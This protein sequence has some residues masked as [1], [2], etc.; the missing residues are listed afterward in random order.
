MKALQ[1]LI[2][3]GAL[4]AVSWGGG[5]N[6]TSML[7]GLQER[8]IRP[9]LILFADT[10]G[11]KPETYEHIFELD[12]W[13]QVHGM[14]SCLIV[15]NRSAHESLEAECLTNKTLPGLAFGN[16]G[17]SVKWK[18]QPME[19]WAKEWQPAIDCWARGERVRKSIGFDWGEGHRAHIPD[20]KCYTYEYPL[21]EWEW[22]REACVAAIKRAGLKVPS[23]SAC[24]FC[25]N[26]KPWGVRDLLTPEERG[27]V[28]ELERAAEPYKI[29]RAHV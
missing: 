29:G 4:I 16:R 2:D 23:K 18:K 1:E 27:M 20:D 26:Q 28:M 15:H 19:Q 3:D 17:C 7:I 22:D 14:P 6:S 9:D 25:P 24:F 5:V 21:V 13:L 11:E 12:C 8:G 10:G